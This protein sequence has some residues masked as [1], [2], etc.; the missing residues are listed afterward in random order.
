M[1]MSRQTMNTSINFA[2]NLYPLSTTPIFSNSKNICVRNFF[3][4]DFS[5]YE[6]FNDKVAPQF[7]FFF[8]HAN[9]IPAQTYS[10]FFKNVC[11]R[12]PV[13]ILSYDMRG[14]GFTKK[15]PPKNFNQLNNWTVL[16]DDQKNLLESFYSPQE[17][18]FIGG[19][20]LGAWLSYL[21]LD[22]FQLQNLILFDPPILPFW[23]ILKWNVAKII[24]KP[25][26]SPNAIKVKQRKK[27][28]ATREE[29]FER[30]KK[31]NLMKDWESECI[32]NY[33]DAC[34]ELKKDHWYHLRHDPN[35][36][37]RMFEEYPS[38]AMSLFLQL[39]QERRKQLNPV[40]YVGENSDTCNP[41][42]KNWVKFFLPNVKWKTV[43]KG[44]HMFLMTK[45]FSNNFIN[46]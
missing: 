25:E 7:H 1:A 21:C 40:L 20:S 9:G 18:W 15:E 6:Y 26:L 44:E 29:I 35:W 23:T 14:I 24:G 3:E 33:I 28:F 41:N 17:T 43:N 16:L 12:F 31:S 34:F 22:F 10:S 46:I 2:E 13:R 4:K 37:A 38:S 45:E 30:Y 39:S 27:V 42:A 36:E 19:H 11:L 8:A 5:C 32:W